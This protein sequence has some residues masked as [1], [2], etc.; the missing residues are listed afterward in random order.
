MKRIL[1][2]NVRESPLTLN[3]FV[4]NWLKDLDS[5]INTS[6]FRKELFNL[7]SS[8]KLQDAAERKKMW[9][10]GECKFIP[11]AYLFDYKK[12]IVYIFEVEDTHNLKYNKMGKLS[13][14]WWLLDEIGWDLRIFLI[15]RYCGNWRTLP[16]DNTQ[17]IYMKT[18][19]RKKRNID[20]RIPEIK[21]N[22]DKT[23][24]N[25]AKNSWWFPCKL[26]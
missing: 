18:L 14:T 19:E 25:A 1:R 2:E 23:Y 13:D 16:I 24:Q 6:G 10:K 3:K 15:D 9:R 26:T 11:D 8:E 4:V 7:F 20:N 12:R 17:F 21:I 5:R 22:W